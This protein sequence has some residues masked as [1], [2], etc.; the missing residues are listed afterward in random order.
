MVFYSTQW[1]CTCNKIPR[2]R[3]RCQNLL[4]SITTKKVSFKFKSQTFI[5]I[6]IQE[7]LYNYINTWHQVLKKDFQKGIFCVE[8]FQKPCCSDWQQLCMKSYLPYTISNTLLPMQAAQW[9]NKSRTFD[10]EKYTFGPIK[11][12]EAY[13][14]SFRLSTLHFNLSIHYSE[15]IN[16]R[17]Q[18]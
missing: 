12:N 17:K 14:R 2:S 9:F 8:G 3:N 18:M 13:K 16:T 4:R 10:I 7:Y 15:I 6:L 11:Y 1:G 5:Y